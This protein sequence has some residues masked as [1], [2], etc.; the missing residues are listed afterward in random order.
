M[1]ALHRED[2]Q[3]K[4]RLA[5]RGAGDGRHGFALVDLEAPEQADGK[6][7]NG[8]RRREPPRLRHRH[9]GGVMQPRLLLD[10]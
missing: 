9:M 2:G 7:R 10:A 1:S 5:P 4:P 3:Q 6:P 8:P